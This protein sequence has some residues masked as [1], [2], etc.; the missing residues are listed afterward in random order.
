[1]S[2]HLDINAKG[3][4]VT[5]RCGWFPGVAEMCKSVSGASW[6]KTRS[7]WSYPLSMQTLRK[8]RSVFGDKIAP[9]EQLWDWAKAER[10]RERATAHLGA[11]LDAD[12]KVVPELA[13]TIAEAMATR[14]YQ[15]SGAAFLATA[16]NAIEADEPGLGKTITS[17]A[18]IMESGLWEGQHLVVCPKTSV[19]ATWASQ[20]KRWTGAEVHAM[21]E[22]AGARKKAISAFLE[23]TTPTKFLVVNKEMMR[24]ERHRF[25]KK[26]EMWEP[27]DAAKWPIEHHL[28][29]H[30]GKASVFGPALRVNLWPEVVEH[31]WTTVIVDEAHSLMASYKPSNKSQMMQGLMDIRSQKKI[32][33]TG[34]PIRGHE[35]N[36]WGYFQWLDVNVGGYWAF[37]DTYF[38]IAKGYFGSSIG[39]L[40]EDAREEFERLL[41]RYMLRRTK[42]EVRPE[43]PM[44]SRED[45]I[46]PLEGRH[47]KQY[48][49]F[50]KM[51]EVAL[52]EGSVSGKGVLSEITRL[53]QMS[54]G[55]W[56]MVDGKMSPTGVAPK[57][58][59][60][61]DSF[62][63]ER[64]I[65]GSP[66]A[67]FAPE[68]DG[69]KFVIASQFNEILDSIAMSLDK[70]KIGHL[71]IDGSVSG[72]RR[73][74][75]IDQFNRDTRSD[76]SEPRILL[77]NSKAGGESID[78]DAQCDEMVILDETFM[79]DDQI[80]LE[81]RINNRSGRVA[82]RT[83]WYVRTEGTVEEN[84]H[85]INQGQHSLQHRLLDGRRGVET[86]LHIIS[87]KEG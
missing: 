76:L 43:L 18:G 16:G 15:R 31:S 77:L 21:P 73:G 51:G 34:T 10:V 26:C 63:A 52:E 72:E 3:D 65:T 50:S 1:M 84:M 17:L 42:I 5:L 70:A 23:S 7:E 28:E 9:S 74:K 60:L 83:W 12:L 25:C 22:G 46:V 4:R 32:A 87:G 45:I 33:L 55:L 37:A 58:E 40:R 79:A 19:H 75:V 2:V 53:R 81:G 67:D 30:E 71:R 68:T 27:K 62:L 59:W 29:E 85:N 82:P 35:L 41:D 20:I 54:Y 8:L 86:A 78:L 14:T 56:K 47:R 38:D 61:V 49:E 57:A 36:L 48:D 13:S 66:K 39:G 69:F 6:S 64:G 80:Q 24:R 11:V 44:G